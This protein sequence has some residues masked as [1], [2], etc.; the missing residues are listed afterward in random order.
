MTNLFDAIRGGDAPAV[1]SLLASNPELAGSRNA[2]G[3]TPALWAVYTR[4]PE[5][6]DTVLAGREPDFFEA[7]ALGNRERVSALLTLDG[8]LA[9]QYSAD[10]FTPLG[11]AIFFGHE[12]VARQLVDAG[13]DVDRPSRNATRVAP[14]HSAV[15][16]GSVA[17]VK[18]LLEHG[19]HPD[20]AEFLEATPL[21]SAAGHG[22]HEMVELLLAAGADR[23][24][25]TK[26]GKTAEDLARQYGH[27]E[28]A[29]WL[30]N[31]SSSAAGS[32][33]T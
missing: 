16:S 8:K 30:A 23:G 25:K 3:T 21:H 14:L 24:R 15:A 2:E 19:A 20:G 12:E 1:R 10:G 7:C 5:L 28:L 29:D 33:G 26:D 27:A 13:A 32:A 4:H 11:L 18:L 9:D 31:Y 22:N 17:L 6:A